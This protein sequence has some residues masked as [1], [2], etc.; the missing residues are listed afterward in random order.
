MVSDP[1]ANEWLVVVEQWTE[2]WTDSLVTWNASGLNVAVCCCSVLCLFR[3][4]LSQSMEMLQ[5]GLYM[6]CAEQ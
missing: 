1:R 5:V 2:D 4:K 3:T 6:I